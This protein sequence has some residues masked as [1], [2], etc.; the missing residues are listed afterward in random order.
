METKCK[1][2]I[3]E[4]NSGICDRKDCTNYP[5]PTLSNWDGKIQKDWEDFIVI[6]EDKFTPEFCIYNI[7]K[8]WLEKIKYRDAALL[9]L[10]E[11]LYKKIPHEGMNRDCCNGCEEAYIYNEALDDFASHIRH[12]L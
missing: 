1:Q 7:P 12:D 4:V 9:E 8:F 3:L 11:S 6:N 5:K 10:K 2:C